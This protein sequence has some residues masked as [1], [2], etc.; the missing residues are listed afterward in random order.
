MNATLSSRFS[1]S[2]FGN[3]YKTRSPCHRLKGNR[4]SGDQC[5][6]VVELKLETR[7][8]YR[9]PWTPLRMRSP[10]KRVG[11]SRG[12][13]LSVRSQWADEIRSRGASTAEGVGTAPNGLL[14]F[15]WPPNDS[16]LYACAN[17][18]HPRTRWRILPV[19][20]RRNVLP[21]SP[22]RLSLDALHNLARNGGNDG[23]KP[24][25]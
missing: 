13:L 11:A 18:G 22:S 25:V 21:V 23:A 3:F 7:T 12:S 6:Q 5:R 8:S 17:L 19:G 14:F 9:A 16:T 1:A 20:C 10:R 24:T 4:K 15:T 2:L